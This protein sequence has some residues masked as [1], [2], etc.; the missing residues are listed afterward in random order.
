MNMLRFDGKPRLLAAVAACGVLAACAGCGGDSGKAT[1]TGKVAY[2]GAPVTGGTLTLYPADGPAYPITINPDGTFNISGAPIGAMGVGIK[3]DNAGSAGFPAMPSGRTP[4]KDAVMP[5][6]QKD[7][8]MSKMGKKVDI[9]A[10]YNDLKTSGLTW[11]IKAGKNT[12]DFDLA[13]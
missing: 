3:T 12:K 5:Q 8:D 13:D 2:K 11:D 6:N 1:V 4:P 9:P 10:K 7:Y